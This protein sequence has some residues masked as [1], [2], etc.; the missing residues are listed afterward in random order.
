M[1]ARVEERIL[2]VSD[3]LW[4]I[5]FPLP[6]GI[7]HIHCYVLR[8]DDG[9]LTVVDTGLGVDEAG[10]RW[11]AAL[12]RIEGAVER[13]VI[14]HYH[15]DHVGAAADVAALTGAPVFQGALDYEQCVQVWGSPSSD[16]FIEYLRVHGMPDDQVADVADVTRYL[17]NRVHWVRDPRK[18]AAGDTISGWHVHH[19]PGHADG[20][21]ALERDG[22]LIAG[23]A[24]LATISPNVG[25]YPDS[26][27][28]P[29]GDYLSSL[30][31]I[32]ELEPTLALGGHGEPMKDPPARARALVEHHAERLQRTLE[33][34][35]AGPRTAY[36]VSLELFPD[37]LAA[38]LRRFALTETRAHLER[39]VF[40][41]RAERLDGAG[42]RYVA[43]E[44]A[45]RPT[46]V[47]QG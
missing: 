9:S 37:E 5:T 26:R 36:Q 30:G 41:G 7:D 28:D 31:R 44:R 34:I 12:A 43:A 29:L 16:R 32:V 4:R 19:L 40:D 25:L 1:T 42:I 6:L 47:V 39:L 24:L 18:L 14:T 27:P 2:E 11:R 45:P 35:A 20:H 21:L 3:G 13:I 8:A 15:P 46:P 38:V 10:E 33:A 23:D 22:V 17:Q